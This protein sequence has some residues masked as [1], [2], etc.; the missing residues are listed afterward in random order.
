MLDCF[1]KVLLLFIPTPHHSRITEYRGTFFDNLGFRRGRAGL[2]ARGL[3]DPQS[4]R[5]C[6]CAANGWR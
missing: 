6:C 2:T 1:S 3:D 5:Q 4:D